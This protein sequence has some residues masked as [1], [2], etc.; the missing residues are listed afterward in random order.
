MMEKKKFKREETDP[1]II[2]LIKELLRLG[3]IGDENSMKEVERILKELETHLSKAQIDML[4]R[5][6]SKRLTWDRLT[7]RE[8]AALLDNLPPA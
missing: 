4:L 1:G 3:E 6:L 2:E 8:K 5:H 7:E